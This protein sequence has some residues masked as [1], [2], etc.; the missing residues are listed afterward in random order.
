MG[1]GYAVLV[2]SIALVTQGF[3][4]GADTR[5]RT[6]IELELTGRNHLFPEVFRWG[7]RALTVLG[8]L[9]CELGITA[10]EAVVR[11]VTVDLM[12]VQVLQRERIT[13]KHSAE[14]IRSLKLS[15]TSS[16]HPSQLSTERDI[17]AWFELE[18]EKV[19]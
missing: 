16:D 10:S 13:E 8:F 9:V 4:S 12:F 19:G 15:E 14:K 11:D 3:S 17:L 7:L 18:R 6:G 2:G 1:S 5:H